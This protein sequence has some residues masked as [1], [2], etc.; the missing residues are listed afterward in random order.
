MN[1]SFDKNQKDT[2]MKAFEESIEGNYKYAKLVSKNNK[3]DLIINK[4]EGYIDIHK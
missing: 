1:D 4:S 3:Y 2:F